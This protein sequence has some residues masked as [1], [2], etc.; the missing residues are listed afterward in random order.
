MRRKNAGFLESMKGNALL[1]P[2]A[3]VDTTFAC[4]FLFAFAMTTADFSQGAVSTLSGLAICVGS[5]FFSFLVAKKR[6]KNGICTGLVCGGIIFGLILLLNI[7]FVREGFS[8]VLFS[9]LSMIM[10]C[11]VIGGIIGVNSKIKI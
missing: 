7:I 3:G 4:L 9:K 2:P 11:S 8:G 1:S 5:Y 10:I 6:R